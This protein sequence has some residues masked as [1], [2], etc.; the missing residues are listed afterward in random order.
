VNCFG[1]NGFYATDTGFLLD[2]LVSLA[3]SGSWPVAAIDWNAIT[4][5]VALVQLQNGSIAR[6]PIPPT[7]DLAYNFM[8]CRP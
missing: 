5:G 1:A 3:T 4:H 7:C 2:D 6:V 8:E